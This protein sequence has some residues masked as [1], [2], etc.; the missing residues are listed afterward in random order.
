MAISQTLYDRILDE[1]WKIKLVDTHEHLPQ[2]NERIKAANDLFQEFF[3]HYASSDLISSGMS[4]D[5][6]EFIRD[7]EKS[8]EKRWKT[9]EPYWENIQNTGYARSLNIAAKGLFNEDGLTS[10]TYKKI[11]EKMTSFS[12]R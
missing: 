11:A 4:D 12:F 8:I 3:S 2:E 9:L 1:L 7:P 10:R 5:D 6:L